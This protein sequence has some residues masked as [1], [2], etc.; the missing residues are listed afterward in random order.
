MLELKGGVLSGNVV[1]CK[2]VLVDTSNLFTAWAMT[3][4]IFPSIPRHEYIFVFKSPACSL[5]Q[6]FIN[7]SNMT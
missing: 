2:I 4:N 3:E 7:Y 1:F 5:Q 6:C